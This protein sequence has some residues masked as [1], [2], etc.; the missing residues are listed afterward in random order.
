MR[1][2]TKSRKKCTIIFVL[3]FSQNKKSEIESLKS[4]TPKAEHQLK[5]E[6]D[7]LKNIEGRQTTITDNLEG[8]LGNKLGVEKRKDYLTGEITSLK[9]NREIQEIVSRVGKGCDEKRI[10]ELGFKYREKINEDKEIKALFESAGEGKLLKQLDN[11][12]D[13]H[14]YKNIMQSYMKVY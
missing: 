4:E 8:L 14:T 13:K 5:I 9:T 2:K 7:N 11:N 1:R 12:E 10:K 6:E 3:I